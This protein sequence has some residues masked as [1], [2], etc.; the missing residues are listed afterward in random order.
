VK[1]E[2]FEILLLTFGA[3]DLLVGFFSLRIIFIWDSQA[4]ELIDSRVGVFFLSV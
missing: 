1:E 3:N 2:N 4:L